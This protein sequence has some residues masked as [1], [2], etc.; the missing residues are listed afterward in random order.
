LHFL[1]M[2]LL[3]GRSLR[4]VIQEDGPLLLDRVA[5][6]IGQLAVALDLARLRR[7]RTDR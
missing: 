2:E 4:T 5:R 6:L 7:Y 3:A 1:V